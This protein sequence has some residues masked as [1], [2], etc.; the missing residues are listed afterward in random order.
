VPQY[1]AIFAGRAHE[2]FLTL[3][4]GTK[5]LSTK[6]VTVN[7]HLEIVKG[8]N[9]TTWSNGTG[10][11]QSYSVVLGGT[12]VASG[13]SIA[14]N[15]DTVAHALAP[16]TRFTIDRGSYE[17]AYGSNGTLDLSVVFSANANVVSGGVTI[18]STASYPPSGTVNFTPSPISVSI[19]TQP[20]VDPKSAL[21]GSSVAIGL[22][23]Q[24]AAYTHDVTWTSGALS[25]SVGTGLAT[26]ATWT[27][28][29]V[30]GQFPGQTQSPIT[31][32]AVTKNGATVIGTKSVTLMAWNTP[33]SVDYT[34]LAPYDLRVVQVAWDGTRLRSQSPIVTNSIKLV[35]TF[36]STPTLEIE[37]TGV[38]P[39]ADKNY[40][41]NLVLLEV[42]TGSSWRSTGLLFV[43]SRS[44]TDD[45]NPSRVTKWTGVEYVNFLLGRAYQVKDYKTSG[46][47]TNA[48]N[49]FRSMFGGAKGRGWGPNIAASFPADKT[50]AG[51]GWIESGGEREI[52]GGTPYSQVLEAFVND[53]WCEFRTHYDD[54]NGLA[55]LDLY[56]PLT[57]SD[58]TTGGGGIVANFATAPIEQAPVDWSMEGIL[59]RVWAKGDAATGDPTTSEDNTAAPMASAERTAFNA[60][61]FG[62]MEG[63]ASASGQTTAAG[64]R[65]VAKN[66]LANASKSSS[67]QF[68]YSATAVSRNLLPYVTFRPGD[69]VLIPNDRNR[70]GQP[71]SVRVMQVTIDRNADGTTIT[72]ICG[73]LFPAGA[74]ASIAKRIKASTGNRIAGGTLKEPMPLQTIVPAA[75]NFASENAAVSTG[76]WTSTGEARSLVNFTWE[77]VATALDGI[78]PLTVDYYE[79]WWRPDPGTPWAL[80]TFSSNTSVEM[81]DWPVSTTLQF[82]VRGRSTAGVFGEFSAYDEVTTAAPTASIPALA[83]SALYSNGLGT[84]FA[85]WNGNLETGS[86]V[87]SYFA[88]MNAEISPDN[89]SDAPTGAWT[90]KGNSL[91]GAGTVTIQPGA[92]GKWWVR[93]RAYDALGGPGV[94]G[95]AQS[96]TLVDPATI[97][98]PT[99]KTPT[100][101]S[102]TAGANWDAL[103]VN[104]GDYMALSWT[105]PG[106]TVTNIVPDPD[107]TGINY[108]VSAAGTESVVGG[109]YRHTATGAASAYVYAQP[110][111]GESTS[112]R[113][114]VTIGEDLAFRAEVTNPNAFSIWVRLGLAFYNSAGSNIGGSI[115]KP[116]QELAAGATV[117]LE[118]TGVVPSNSGTTTGTLPLLYIYGSSSGGNLTAGTLTDTTKWALYRGAAPTPLRYV[119]GAMPDDAYG[120]YQW[121]G[122]VNASPT[123]A[124]I[125]IDVDGNQIGVAYQEI[126]GRKN[127]GDW[128]NVLR[129]ATG[130]SYDIP[131][132]RGESWSYRVR[133]VGV[134]GGVSDWS[135]ETAPEVAD[136]GLGTLPNPSAPE[137]TSAK[138]SL[139]VEWN[140]LTSTGTAYP[141]NSGFRYAYVQVAPDS[142]VTPGTPGTWERV[143]SAFPGRAGTSIINGLALGASYHARIVA[144]DGTG[145]T[146][147]GAS[148]GPTPLVGVSSSDIT[149]GEILGT[150]LDPDFANGATITGATIQTSE[151]ASRGVKVTSGGLVAYDASGNATFLVDAATG[152]LWFGAGTISGNAIDVSTIDVATLQAELITNGIGD[153]LTIGATSLVSIISGLRSDV[154]EQGANLSTY[155]DFGESGQWK[156]NADQAVTG[157]RIASTSAAEAFNTFSFSGGFQIRR[158]STA[159]AWW[160]ADPNTPSLVRFTTPNITVLNDLNVGS[161]K[162]RPGAAGIT[163][164]SAK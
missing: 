64:V 34:S 47:G 67:R 46:S 61:V 125:P 88:Y 127:G 78:T 60:N 151:T 5:N 31:I 10:G 73:D 118:M 74:T 36:C 157:L 103:G 138:A 55:Y 69:W 147:T 161:H 68:S 84:I 79:V 144:V 25:G 82:R 142:T 21:V 49:I 160:E 114:T 164:I 133:A 2:L 140:G 66:A 108:W 120:D 102:A 71:V 83:I 136:A 56:N 87:P 154:D 65:E 139:Y 81:V 148:V 146:A 89:G 52:S 130:S 137:V 20:T 1:K 121:A 7:Y 159:L 94:N 72:V 4:E 9:R 128:A 124:L 106:V 28:P 153:S 150:S 22:P 162:M 152:S 116:V 30:T 95:P 80:R 11:G 41:G 149:P 112:G 17:F 77:P 59:D 70:S 14:F 63:W 98:P 27:V 18:M 145:A 109:M 134:D 163:I 110:A 111:P 123:T 113:F 75:P 33:P 45:I 76:Y 141:N 131:V 90:V 96:I 97:L 39:G 15:F 26:S 50:S 8:V 62:K 53:G 51:D 12:T 19:A 101:L 24:N 143:G 155:F 35:D 40:Q 85:D 6:T 122:V 158:G 135:N 48:G 129:L 44:N 37:T 42:Q 58:W 100:G 23:R 117:T 86:G 54:N 29:D 104:S 57:G 93:F 105:R 92:Y 132:N 13:T 3:S 107:T 32:T 91:Q 99:P 16:G 38:V 115:L 119:S 43:L 156:S 126:E